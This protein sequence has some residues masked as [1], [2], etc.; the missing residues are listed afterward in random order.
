MSDPSD[1]KIEQLVRSVLAAVDSRLSDIRGEMHQLAA[2]TQERHE[3]LVKEVRDLE[4]RLSGTGGE[5]A[6]G[7]ARLDQSTLLLLER[8][9][10][11]QQRSIAATNERFELINQ[12]LEQL[13]NGVVVPAVASA[14]V[15]MPSLEAMDAPFRMSVS[16][17]QIPITAPLPI[18]GPLPLTPSTEASI[19]PPVL[20]PI[21]PLAA[22]MTVP[23]TPPVIDAADNADNEP[24]D[25]S[26]LADLVSE[27]LGQLSLP[28]QHH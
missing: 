9:E 19:P 3:L 27:H 16:N 22:P 13:T 2:A 6:G 18:T 28:P 1:E 26:R 20:A 17:E 25:I 8:I 21:P 23:F 7:D 10:S 11:T 5:S 24:I 14:A 4:R 12:S 15:P